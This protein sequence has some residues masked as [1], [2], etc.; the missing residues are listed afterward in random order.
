MH[1]FRMLCIYYPINFQIKNGNVDEE[2]MRLLTSYKD[3][4]LNKFRANVKEAENLRLGF[5]EILEDCLQYSDNANDWNP[6]QEDDSC[7]EFDTTNEHI[8]YDL[9]GVRPSS[10]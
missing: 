8:I 6:E 1:L 10:C 4:M 5:Q 7:T 3:C 2:N 9:C